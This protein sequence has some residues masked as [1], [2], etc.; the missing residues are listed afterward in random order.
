VSDV[1]I[2]CNGATVVGRLEELIAGRPMAGPV[3]G[4]RQKIRLTVLVDGEDACDQ[5][6]ELKAAAGIIA[7]PMNN[8]AALI[9]AAGLID[10]EIRR[11]DVDALAAQHGCEESGDNARR[12]DELVRAIGLIKEMLIDDQI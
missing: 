2:C 11:L 1:T 7:G 12:H 8:R 9:I 10:A 6:A 3:K 5:V 4:D